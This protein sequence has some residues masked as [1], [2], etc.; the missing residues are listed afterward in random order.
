MNTRSYDAA[1]K[2]IER[3]AHPSRA[4]LEAKQKILFHLGTQYF[5]NTQFERAILYFNQSIAL[6]QYN[7]QTKANALY[8]RGESYYRLNRMQEAARNFNDY[9]SLTTQKNTEMY[10]LAYYNL[11]Y[12]T[13]HK[14]DYATA[15]D[16]FQ[17]FIQLQK[18]GDATVLADAYNRIGDCH[19]QARRFD[20][21]KQYYTRAENLGT[22]AGD[23]S[24]YQLA[25]VAGLQKN[26]DGKVALLNQLANKYPNS[27]YAINALYEKGRSYVQSRNNSQA[28]ATFR[29][30]LNKY[31]ESPV[32]RKA[33]AEIGLLYYQND[34]YDRAIEAYK[35]VITKYPGS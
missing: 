26:Y 16:R 18:S 5:A 21:A 13:F 6:G 15:Q 30:L 9:L 32:S 20:E 3:I 2:S 14:K 4:I 12:I 11:A 24:Y 8:W 25:L 17:K 28:I 31:P 34:D 1:L 29:E 10:A 27:P 22:P 19:M 23:Y 7:L 33:A 35:H